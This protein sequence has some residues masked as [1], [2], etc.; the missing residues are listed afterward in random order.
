MMSSVACL[1]WIA[2][3]ALAPAD[4]SQLLPAIRTAYQSN[5]AA[6]GFGTIRFSLV[7]GEAS[8]PSAA[9]SGELTR[10][11]TAEGFLAYGGKNIRYDCIYPI[12]DEVAA[13]VRISKN[14]WSSLIGS[15]RF[16]TAGDLTL[17]D[18]LF[19]DADDK[20]VAHSAQIMPTTDFIFQGINIPL[21]LGIP[22]P[23]G[24][25]L[26]KDIEALEA[27]K[28]GWTLG[29][30]EEDVLLG[31][32]H[33]V[34]LSVQSRDS[35]D[36][37][38]WVDLDR[39]AVPVQ[40][41]L[42]V[43]SPSGGIQAT[44]QTNF[45]DL[46]QVAGKAWVPFRQTMFIMP[47]RVRRLTII[48]ADFKTPPPPTTYRMEFPEAMGMANAAALVTY[49]TKQKVWDLSHLPSASDPKTVKIVMAEPGQPAPVM[50]GPYRARSWGKIALV[51]IG[52]VLL[53]GAVV[54]AL[55]LKRRN[56]A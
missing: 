8:S 31:G 26:D 47:N 6:L 30:V 24:H 32:L 40:T 25:V 38:Y 27:G 45:D 19:V 15:R 49:T 46:R 33:V 43:K 29:A 14:S 35:D 17:F 36:M 28:E 4:H 48:E 50:P 44:I 18:D 11:F 23:R 56:N 13:R 22:R 5:R 21:N 51:T 12:E 1:P 7:V 20:T 42:T 2:F 3:L 39:G 37:E 10:P 54:T 16:I 53:I 52:V 9:S 34:R 55:N 41:R